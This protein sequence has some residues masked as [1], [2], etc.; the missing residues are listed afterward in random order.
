MKKENI[1]IFGGMFIYFVVT[2]VDRFVLKID[3]FIYISLLLIAS[4]L[5]IVGI[6]QNRINQ[7]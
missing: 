2:I 5:L 6:V 1:C 3:N 7:G 4:V